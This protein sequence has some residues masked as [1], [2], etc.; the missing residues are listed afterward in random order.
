MGVNTVAFL[1]SGL[2][3][4]AAVLSG[5]AVVSNSTLAHGSRRIIPRTSNAG[6]STGA[7][8]GI[9][10]GVALCTIFAISLVYYWI[11]LRNRRVSAFPDPEFHY[12]H[13]AVQYARPP[14]VELSGSPQNAA[15]YELES[16][17]PVNSWRMNV[18]SSQPRPVRPLH[19]ISIRKLYLTCEKDIERPHQP[20]GTPA[21]YG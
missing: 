6:L 12:A 9:G 1:N 5:L 13:P 18:A 15:S 7:K 3:V 17:P 10:V 14:R 11:V 2:S 19:D 16:E 20:S 4:G 8:A 21:P